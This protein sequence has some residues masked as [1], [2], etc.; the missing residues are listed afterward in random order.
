[1]LLK[2]WDSQRFC[3]KQIHTYRHPYL[4]RSIGSWASSG[5]IKQT[6]NDQHW[7]NEMNSIKN[8]SSY[9]PYDSFSPGVTLSDRRFTGLILGMEIG[10]FIKLIW[11]EIC[12][13]VSKLNHSARLNKRNELKWDLLYYATNCYCG[14]CLVST[15]PSKS[16]TIIIIRTARLVSGEIGQNKIK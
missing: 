12:C 11:Y 5:T 16:I 14:W 6:N 8:D 2:K 13:N 9:L 7:T 15:A 1:M 3:N 10:H 4:Y